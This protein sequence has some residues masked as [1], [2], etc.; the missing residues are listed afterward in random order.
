VIPLELSAE[1]IGAETDFVC[2]VSGGDEIGEAELIWTGPGELVGCGNLRLRVAPSFTNRMIGDVLVVNP[3]RGKVRRLLRADSRSNFFLVTEQC[4]Q[5]CVMCSQ[6]P[7]TSHHDRFWQFERAVELAPTDC[8]IVIT[9]GEPTL[10]K[11]ALFD[12]LT[13]A[14]GRRR[15]VTFHVLSSAQHL[16][17]KDGDFLTSLAGRS[18]SWGVPL[19]AADAAT[20]DAIVGKDGAYARLMD[21]LAVLGRT[22]ANLELRTVVMT[23]NVPGLSRLGRFIAANLP[24]VST[25][26][27]MQLERAGFARNR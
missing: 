12:F 16:D 15:D 13:R 10:H 27:V 1:I 6:P 3:A 9:G 17:D 2:R 23:N 11:A 7:K 21:G 25:W 4:D 26:A 24:F 14:Y 18:T 22:G 5:L 8:R 20:H 19:Y